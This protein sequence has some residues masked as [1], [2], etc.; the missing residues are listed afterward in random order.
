[1]RWFDD[2][3]RARISGANT[4]LITG[5]IGD[6]F[7]RDALAKIEF[8]DTLDP[9]A[10]TI[11]RRLDDGAICW[12]FDAARGFSFPRPEDQ[13]RFIAL[14]TS[15]N[16]TPADPNDPIAQA[17]EN[18]DEVELPTNPLAALALMHAVFTRAM[19]TETVDD[20]QT[21]LAIIPDADVIMP[22]ASAG[23]DRSAASAALSILHFATNDAFTR[24][25]HVLI[26]S[27]PTA[28][29][30]EERIR[31]PESPVHAITIGKPTQEERLEYLTHLCFDKSDEELRADIEALEGQIT[32]AQER[33]RVS[34]ETDLNQKRTDLAEHDAN[35]EQ[36]LRNER[37]VSEARSELSDCESEI[38]RIT[39]DRAEADARQKAELRAE[40]DG[41]TKTLQTDKRLR[42]RAASDESWSE[43][44]T[45]DLVCVTISKSDGPDIEESKTV[46]ERFRGGDVQLSRVGSKEDPHLSQSG[47]PIRFSWTNGAICGRAQEGDTPKNWQNVKSVKC[48][49]IARQQNVDRQ[50]EIRDLLAV[51][52]KQ[53]TRLAELARQIPSLTDAVTR[54]ERQAS[55][56]WDAQ[57]EQIRENIAQLERSL[58]SI[59]N[60]E[61]SALESRLIEAREA[62]T[63]MHSIIRF[64]LPS[65]G[66]E[67][68]ARLTQGFGYRD[69]VNL[70]RDARGH[71]R[72]IGHVEIVAN[73]QTILERVYGHLVEIVDPSYGFEGIAG[74]DDTKTFFMDTRDAITRGD[75]RDAPMGALLMGPPGTGK[76][77]IAEAF[78]KECGFLF[79]KLRSIRSM[80]VGESERQMEEVLQA[81]RDLSPVVVLR[82]EVDEED[83]GRDSYQG[84]SGISGR[85]RRMW[86]SFLSD[87]VIRGRVFVISCT[88]RPDRMDAA[89]KRS[90]R[91]DER[92][93]LLMPD[94]ETRSALFPV[95]ARRYQFPCGLEDFA[96]FATKTEGLSGADIEVIVRRA[97]AFVRRSGGFAIDR[98][99][100]LFAIGDFIPSASRYDI[101]RMSLA[102]ISETSSRSYLPKNASALVKEFRK[103][104]DG[105]NASADDDTSTSSSKK[106]STPN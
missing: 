13:E 20:R 49:P 46:L 7:P 31:R 68:L 14:M 2:L 65:I 76:T 86:M 4:F 38:E 81:L 92:I 60:P 57:R 84:D 95:M 67:E 11:R 80:W 27:A 51:T 48:I 1:M 47:G 70:L 85:M 24:A 22:A 25:G 96:E 69:I 36:M 21:C 56:S 102:A 63:M 103:I 90:G 10:D 18:L 15:E 40:L 93:P 105:R 42:D 82:D 30:L 52:P 45:G 99:A 12:I 73:R 5:G 34:L 98:A 39:R 54:A 104:V 53:S 33:A 101:A 44:R 77:A 97:Y 28:N 78:A 23:A 6:G 3:N 32:E 59:S 106:T 71:D 29:A 62:I 8:V 87:P 100:L 83:S 79:V 66:L 74:L 9:L 19:S 94:H 72:E 43:L 89:L 91:T 26:L 64:P 37:T 17:R 55:V 35:R 88:N 16:Q 75:T 61:I 41:L 50:A 58:Q